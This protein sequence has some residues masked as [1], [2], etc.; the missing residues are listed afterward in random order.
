MKNREER[1]VLEGNNGLKM[2]IMLLFSMD[3]KAKKTYKAHVKNVKK[4]IVS[5]DM[6]PVIDWVYDILIPLRA[7]AVVKAIGDVMDSN[8]KLETI[9]FRAVLGT[10]MPNPLLRDAKGKILK[11]NRAQVKKAKLFG[12]QLLVSLLLDEGVFI[13]TTE[14]IVGLMGSHRQH[15]L[16]FVSTN[17]REKKKGVEAEPGKYYQKEI[18]ERRPSKLSKEHAKNYSSTGLVLHDLVDD[19]ILEHF[20]ELKED[21]NKT[22]DKDGN[23]LRWQGPFKREHYQLIRDEIMSLKD[24]IYYIVHK[25]DHRLRIGPDANRLEGINLHGKT[26]ETAVHCTAEAHVLLPEAKELLIQQLYCAL[27]T[28][29]S[30]E[31]AVKRIKPADFKPITREQLLAAKSQKEMANLLI[32]YKALESLGRLERGEPDN[33]LFGW[34]FTYSGGIIAG[35]LFKSVGFCKSGNVYGLKRLVDHHGNTLKRLN[36][37]GAAKSKGSKQK[38]QLTRDE[39]KNAAQGVNHGEHLL[40]YVNKLATLGL[41]ITQEHLHGLMIEVYGECFD[42]IDIMAQFGKVLSCSGYSLM[43]WTMPDKEIASHQAY[44]TGVMVD[45]YI[46]SGTAKDSEGKPKNYIHHFQQLRLPYETDGDGKCLYPKSVERNKK[47]YD[48][49]PHLRGLYADI[50]HSFDAYV[51]RCIERAVWRAGYQILTKH[52]NFYVH[53]NA[54]PVVVKAAKEALSELFENNYL[55]G[56]LKEIAA[57]SPRDAR[58]PT[59]VYGNAKNK[60]MESDL[61]LMP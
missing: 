15:F 1:E 36:K 19:E 43:R 50:I 37:Y 9:A 55:E 11:L 47:T 33:N 5:S 24:S 27:H 45:S 14:T 25:Y 48:M 30:I 13:E 6:G 41:D 59:L 21:W 58:A 10:K 17:V 57:N 39:S 2:A 29:V 20:H 3:C 46:P 54:Y 31:E 61:F 32:A 8:E 23:L 52:D 60:V 44:V 16:T 35:V 12:A 40:S 7:K 49:Q 38:L 22:H 56:V 18:A 42:N 51:R 53:L 4:G 28:R 26:F 34:D